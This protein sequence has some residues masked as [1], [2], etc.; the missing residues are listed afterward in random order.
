MSEGAVSVSDELIDGV[1][2]IKMSALE[3]K[4]KLERNGLYAA[5][6]SMEAVIAILENTEDWLARTGTE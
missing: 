1:R 6:R 5:H 3:L 4:A 2:C